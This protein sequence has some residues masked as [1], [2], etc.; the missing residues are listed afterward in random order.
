MQSL[1]ISDSF[2][3]FSITLILLLSTK[4]KLTCSPDPPLSG[5]GFGIK[6]KIN[7]SWK[8]IS[9]AIVLNKKALSQAFKASSKPKV[10]SN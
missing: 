6:D 1:A 4:L 9:F 8:A 10:S 7:P 2:P 3:S 5:I